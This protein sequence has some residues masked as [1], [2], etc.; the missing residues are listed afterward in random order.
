MSL[1]SFGRGLGVGLRGTINK[2]TKEKRHEILQI[3][4]K[5]GAGEVKV[6]G[7]R[8]H[9]EG[10]P[11]SDLDV[12][13]QLNPRST[14]LNLTAIQQ[15]LEDLPA[16]KVDVLTGAAISPYIRDKVLKEAVPL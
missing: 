1:R 4:R 9:G 10:Q 15:E 12:L 3:A 7:S 5:H 6:F 16:C 14:L 2:T 8:A 13:V 11:D